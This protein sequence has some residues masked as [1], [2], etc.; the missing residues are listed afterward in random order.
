[1][2]K[3]LKIGPWDHPKHPKSSKKVIKFHLR[4]SKTLKLVLRDH[5]KHPKIVILMSNPSI[6]LG[7][8]Q[9]TPKFQKMC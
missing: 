7:E 5:P 4:M 8:S 3:F 2:S 1:M 6:R 9:K